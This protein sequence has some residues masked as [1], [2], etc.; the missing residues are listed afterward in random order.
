MEISTDSRLVNLGNT[1]A[2]IAKIY[3]KKTN[4]VNVITS[5]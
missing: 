4:G 3:D 1:F 5:K 2:D